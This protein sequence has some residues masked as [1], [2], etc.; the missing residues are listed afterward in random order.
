MRLKSERVLQRNSK[1]RLL[2][3]CSLCL[4]F[5]DC[6]FVLNYPHADL[7]DYNWEKEEP[8]KCGNTCPAVSYTDAMLWDIILKGICDPDISKV[9]FARKGVHRMLVP[10][11]IEA[12]R[13][14]DLA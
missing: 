7:K 8:R 1:L 12:V 3:C 14:L 13:G 6:D 4:H 11:L 2:C 10:D 9:I 5:V